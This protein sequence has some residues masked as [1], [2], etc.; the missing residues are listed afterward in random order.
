MTLKKLAGIIL[1]VLALTLMGV[2]FLYP[3]SDPQAVDISLND[4]VDATINVEIPERG[5]VGDKENV[6]AVISTSGAPGSGQALTIRSKLEMVGTATEPDGSITSVI[7]PGE[8]AL[9]SWKI[10]AAD[11]GKIKGTLWIY[12]DDVNGAEALLYG[13]EFEFSA[14]NFL[15]LAPLATRVLTGVG[16]VAGLLLIMSRKEEEQ[17]Q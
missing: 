17:I 6:T 12:A 1:F 14:S 2:S 8:S 3:K 11:K 5:W 15:C 4:A 10:R 13:R 16:G 9:F 7:S